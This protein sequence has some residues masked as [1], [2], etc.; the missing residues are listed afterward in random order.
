M[1]NGILILVEPSESYETINESVDGLLSFLPVIL[2]HR[3]KIICIIIFSFVSV[4]LSVFGAYY[5]QVIIDKIIPKGE[6]NI[7]N[8][9]SIG[10][11]I[12]YIVRVLMD[13]FKTK[14]LIIL[15]QEVSK[16]VI[17]RYFE[18]VVQLPVNFFS[19]RK[20]GDIIS[21]FL[22]ASKITDALSTLV[23]SLFID[24]TMLIF[25]GAILFIQNVFLF[26]ITI[27]SFPFYFVTIVFFSRR[28]E[29]SSEEQMKSISTLNSSVIETL[30]GIETVKS[31]KG[32][33]EINLKINRYLK[34]FMADSKINL[35]H[36]SYQSNIKVLIDLI[37][38]GFIVW[39][40]ALSVNHNNLSLGELI[41]YVTLLSY[42]T[43]SLQNIVG[44]QVKVQTAEIASRR[45]NEVL[46]I[47]TEQKIPRSCTLNGI[48]KS[49]KLSKINF[50]Y[51]YKTEI[52]KNINFDIK[53][54]EKIAIVGFSGSGKSTLA[55]LL[56]GFYN[57]Q[58]GDIYYDG[59]SIEDISRK[60]L[61]QCVTYV[62]QET[63]L[64]DGTVLENLCFGMNHDVSNE[65]IE[66]ACKQSGIFDFI[67]KL[68][69]KLNS[70]IDEGGENLSGGQ[71]KRLS[72]ARALL[73][74]SSMYVFDEIT[75]GMDSL[76]ESKVVDNLL[77][78][79]DKTIVFV[80]HNLSI[81]KRCDKIIVLKDGE[82]AECGSYDELMARD[83]LYKKLNKKFDG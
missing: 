40:G 79:V 43:T 49:I 32:E 18:H 58:S 13:I 83:S 56:V 6:E 74:D 72:L 61:R 64:F 3:I 1:W 30:N 75:D 24:F 66:I 15:R 25:V 10:L 29:K 41:T 51:N 22:D 68:P 11:V 63:F 65:E 23:L 38:S 67:E 82:I 16:E 21:R 2:K 69:L 78:L 53:S 59:N 47:E 5:F 52:L 80:T 60:S 4:I 34:E 14:M 9:I 71:K 17:S 37:T 54:G 42:F 81:S 39:W 36:G 19:T 35:F 70:T 12:S 62:P 77:Q 46:S 28:L 73:R 48:N 57:A 55:K 50:S 7:I 33:E 76:L 31:F 26:F 27:A 20:T 44:L 8:V 45:L